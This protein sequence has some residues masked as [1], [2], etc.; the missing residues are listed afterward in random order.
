[1]NLMDKKRTM[2]IV[3]IVTLEGTTFTGEIYNSNSRGL[4]LRDERSTNSDNPIFI[5]HHAIS[6]IKVIG[7]RNLKK[8]L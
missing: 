1:M 4:F 6:H 8:N 3:K 7:W 5:S 2:H